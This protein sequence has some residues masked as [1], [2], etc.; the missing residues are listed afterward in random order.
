MNR[1]GPETSLSADVAEHFLAAGERRRAI[2]RIAQAAISK[3]HISD[4]GNHF[5]PMVKIDN[6]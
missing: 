4:K 1:D 3:P 6:F 5:G 2:F